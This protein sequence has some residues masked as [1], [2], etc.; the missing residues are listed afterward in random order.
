V[1]IRVDY[2][3]QYSSAAKEQ[4]VEKDCVKTTAITI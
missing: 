3:T 4:R 1:E 2:A